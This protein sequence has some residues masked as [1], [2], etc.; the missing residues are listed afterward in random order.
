MLFFNNSAIEF[1]ALDIGTLLFDVGIGRSLGLFRISASRASRSVVIF[2]I[3]SFCVFDVDFN[4]GWVLISA[5]KLA[6]S[7]LSV[8]VIIL[9]GGGGGGGGTGLV[10]GGDG[11]LFGRGGNGAELSDR[12]LLGKELEIGKLNG[13]ACVIGLIGFGNNGFGCIIGLNGDLGFEILNC[14]IGTIGC[15]NVGGVCGIGLNGK[16][17]F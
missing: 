9:F 14:L 5:S 10:G 7:E 4:L 3:F 6:L 12:G 8:D 17:I 16:L 13:E 2:G 15:G 11:A 1:G